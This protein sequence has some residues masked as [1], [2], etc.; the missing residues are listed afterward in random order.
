MPKGYPR[1]RFDIV[2]QTQVQEIVTAVTRNPVA[3]VM[4]PYTSDKG[5]EDWEMLYGLTD[6]TSRKGGINFTKH[7]LPQLL[8]AE[9]LRVGGYVF[10]KR[11]VAD[12]ALTLVILMMPLLQVMQ[13]STLKQK[14]KLQISHC[15]L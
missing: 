10:G 15:L 6:F 14:T 3:V 1:S 9:V 5:S 13:I 4:I 2:D 11:M 7:G 12:N 8:A